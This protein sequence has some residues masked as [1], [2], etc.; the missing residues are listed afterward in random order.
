M[1]IIRTPFDPWRLLLEKRSRGYH[2]PRTVLFFDSIQWWLEIFTY[3]HA[4]EVWYDPKQR[5]DLDDLA[6]WIKWW[7]IW[8]E[9][10]CMWWKIILENLKGRGG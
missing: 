5:R 7:W 8:I 3:I 1:E 9:H 4:K 10:P 6:F 2:V